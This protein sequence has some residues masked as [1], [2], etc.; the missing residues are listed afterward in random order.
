MGYQVSI[1]PKKAE[2]IFYFSMGNGPT[3][4]KATS[5]KQFTNRTPIMSSHQG[6]A[7]WREGTINCE[8]KTAPSSMIRG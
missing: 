6:E 1:T 2:L 3:L 8:M 4:P 7:N 5:T